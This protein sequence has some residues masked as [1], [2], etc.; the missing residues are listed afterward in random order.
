MMPF[1][2]EVYFSV[3]EQYNRAIWPAQVVAYGL[4]LAAVFLTL[5]PVPGGGRLIGAILAAAWAWIGAVYYLAHF[6]AI[7]FA[8][9]AYGAVFVIQGLLFG[10]TM[11]IRGNIAF[12]APSPLPRRA[13][14]VRAD[15]FAWCGLGLV[16]FAMIIHPLVGRLAGQGWPSAPFFGVAPCPTTIFT[17]GLLL[18]AQGRTPLYLV[19]IPALWSLVCGALAWRLNLPADLAVA[20]AGVGGFSL[21]LWK[22]RRTARR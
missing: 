11:V 1:S 7:D 6:A 9:P 5:R 14:E 8:A 21:I 17:L 15:P 4:G 3:L 12:G 2:A 13:G 10:W 19:M 18:L 16:I 20:L 22:N